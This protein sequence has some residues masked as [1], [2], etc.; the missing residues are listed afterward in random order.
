[1]IKKILIVLG[2]LVALQIGG[3]ALLIGWGVWESSKMPDYINKEWISERY[4]DDIEKIHSALTNQISIKKEEKKIELTD[5][6]VA[7]F[8][9][10]NGQRTD[11]YKKYD[12]EIGGSFSSSGAGTANLT[13]NGKSEKF[14]TYKMAVDNIEYL[15]CIRDPKIEPGAN[16]SG[17]EQ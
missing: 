8:T 14:M 17:D 13:L 2:V 5:D 12:T 7:V 16:Q 3:C 1:M 11:I 15:V 4:G 10:I 9:E 6:I